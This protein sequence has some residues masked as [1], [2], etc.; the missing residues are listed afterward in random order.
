FDLWR[1]TAL[2]DEADFSHSDLFAVI[3]KILNVGWSRDHGFYRCCDDKDP[4][5]V[6]SFYVYGPKL[7]ATRENFKD[8]ALESRC[9]TFTAFENVELKPLYR[10]EKFKAQ[11]LKL[12]NKLTLWRFR[13]YHNFKSKVHELENTELLK[14]LYE[15][16]EVKSRIKQVLTPLT[17]ISQELK[18]GIITLAKEVSEALNTTDPEVE[19]EGEIKQALQELMEKQPE[20]ITPLHELH[21]YSSPSEGVNPSVTPLHDSHLYSNPPEGVTSI[22]KVKI[23]DLAQTM[24]MQS[25]GEIGGRALRGLATK[26]SLFFRSY[27]FKVRKEERNLSFV[28]IPEPW[29]HLKGGTNKGVKSVKGVKGVTEAELK[30]PTNM[31]SKGSNVQPQSPKEDE[32]QTWEEI[33]KQLNDDSNEK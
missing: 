25:E 32:D 30:P 10:M 9:L 18:D 1:G 3:T 19:F 31:G 17:L 16:V 24:L 14:E 21:S 7:L 20:L 6:L 26:L 28:Y 4:T 2:I 12:R 22:F 27:G 29:L 13:N 11:A 8:T 23:K 5:K 33:F 15:D